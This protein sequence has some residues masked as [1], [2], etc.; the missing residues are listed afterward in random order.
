MLTQEQANN[1]NAIMVPLYC[2]PPTIY[3][4]PANGGL[5]PY[6]DDSQF[7]ESIHDPRISTDDQAY[8]A[9][10]MEGKKNYDEA[11]QAGWVIEYNDG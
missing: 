1:L 8:I 4:V 10:I 9:L 2:I 5:F 3:Y 11:V 7:A 6:T